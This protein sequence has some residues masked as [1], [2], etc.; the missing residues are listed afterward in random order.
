MVRLL[1]DSGANGRVVDKGGHTALHGACEKG[2]PAVARELLRDGADKE[3][4]V[5]V[6][7]GGAGCGGPGK[8]GCV[9]RVKK[10]IEWGEGGSYGGCWWGGRRR[11]RTGRGGQGAY[12]RG[13]MA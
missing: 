12:R 9:V 13:G 2:H 10:G 6:G 8:G 7:R 4:T 1:L 11:D 5:K 3:A